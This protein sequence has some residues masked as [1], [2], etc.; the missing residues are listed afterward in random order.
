MLKLLLRTPTSRWICVFFQLYLTPKITGLCGSHLYSGLLESQLKVN[1][2]AAGVAGAGGIT[3]PA[4]IPSERRQAHAVQS[5]LPWP[6]FDLTPSLSGWCFRHQEVH[7]R[8]HPDKCMR[9]LSNEAVEEITWRNEAQSGAAGTLRRSDLRL[10]LQMK[11]VLFHCSS[12][13]CQWD[14]HLREV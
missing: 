5:Q 4:V 1:T 13:T 9:R 2:D 14:L 3:L 11:L 8:R 7:V 12:D 6:D 10:N